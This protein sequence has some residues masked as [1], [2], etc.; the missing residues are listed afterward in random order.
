M[1]KLLIMLVIVYL[2]ASFTLVFPDRIMV[3]ENSHIVDNDEEQSDILQPMGER[4][5]KKKN[6]MTA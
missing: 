4:L 6:I 5:T 2:N 1:Y 3:I